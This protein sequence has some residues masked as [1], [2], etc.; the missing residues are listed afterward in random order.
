MDEAPERLIFNAN[1]PGAAL[2]K[3][4]QLVAIP[5]DDPVVELVLDTGGAPGSKVDRQARKLRSMAAGAQPTDPF[6]PAL[7]WSYRCYKVERPQNDGVFRD[8]LYLFNVL[9]ALEWQPDQAYLEQ[10]K[11]AFR[12]ASDFLFDVTDGWMAFGQVVFG[13]PELMESADIQITASTRILPRSWVGAMHPHDEYKHDEKYTPIRLGRGL[14]N[15]NRRGIIPWDEP[16]AYRIIIHEWGHHA[17]KLTDEYLETRQLLLPSQARQAGAADQSA[18]GSTIVVLKV[19]TTSDSIMATTEGTSELVTT[20]WSK[21]RALYMRIPPDRT[22]SQVRP[23]PGRLPMA[24]PRFRGLDGS[25]NLINSAKNASTQRLPAWGNAGIA[26]QFNL[27]SDIALDRCWLYV[28]EHGAGGLTYPKRL[29]AQGTLEART[30]AAPFALL[31]AAPGDT[32]ALIVEQ[33]DRS[34]MV[35]SAAVPDKGELVW[36]VATPPILPAIDVLPER[37]APNEPRAQLRVRLTY[38][39]QPAAE[40]LP[41][42]VGVFPLGQAPGYQA[43]PLQGPYT[44]GWISA[45]QDVPTLDGHVLL[46]W[47]DGSLL[48][49][50]FSQ[51]G[52]GP[53]SGFPY[54]ANPMNAGSADGNALLLMYKDNAED[55]APNDVKVVTALA[56]GLDGAPAGGHERGYAFAIAANRPLPTEFHPTLILYYDQPDEQ[57]GEAQQGD[58]DLVICRRTAD[59]GWASLPTYLPPR[60]RFAVAP[61][62]ERAGESLIAASAAGPRVEYYKVCW[63][64]RE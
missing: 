48:V 26:K 64:P 12:R 53:N 61:L 47:K 22:A 42:Q 29:I 23:G 1:R 30:A 50:S 33:R 63:V 39:S 46:R 55:R 21:L 51:G 44:D 58:G 15:D 11:T 31:G 35:L 38:P 27:P 7:D 2:P 37:V 14:W 34:S 19:A 45:P 40:Q 25:Y 41:D 16:E 13:G 54:P 60:F 5:S 32:L 24:L 56:H 4:G 3:G 59:G 62:D 8:Y 28:L 20:Q 9:V 18:P 36:R 52:D 17:L 43:A 10:L 6:G 57:D 49:S